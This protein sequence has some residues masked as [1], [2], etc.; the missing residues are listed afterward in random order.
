MKV[1][2][3]ILLRDWQHI[4]Q[5]QAL[6]AMGTPEAADFLCESKRYGACA[7][8]IEKLRAQLVIALTALERLAFKSNTLP[9][10]RQI[11]RDAVFAIQEMK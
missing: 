8:E 9:Q 1:D 5:Q 6:E 4:K 10:K 11:A 3:M 7:D 2:F